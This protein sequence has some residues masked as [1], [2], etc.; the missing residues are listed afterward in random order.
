MVFSEDFSVSLGG[1]QARRYENGVLDRLRRV[2]INTGLSV[3]AS[4]HSRPR[5]NWRAS[6]HVSGV[7]RYSGAVFGL[8]L[9]G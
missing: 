1:R 8:L 4:S 6:R 3:E 2:R 7:H 9:V 5:S